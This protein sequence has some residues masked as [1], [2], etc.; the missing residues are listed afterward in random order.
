M[1]PSKKLIELAKQAQLL[2][3]MEK[4]LIYE[5]EHEQREFFDNLRHEMEPNEEDLRKFNEIRRINAQ[6]LTLLT[7][8]EGDI[9][10]NIDKSLEKN[11]DNYISDYEERTTEQWLY[12]VGFRSFK[13]TSN[14]DLGKI[15]NDSN[16]IYDR[17]NFK[18]EQEYIEH[19]A[20]KEE[21]KAGELEYE[22]KFIDTG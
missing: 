13:Q 15:F 21:Q 9:C 8:L 14:D 2:E 3:K 11:S 1:K 18:S 22:I 17:S 12:L 4:N 6:N 5:I 19:L 16:L 10:R 20:W 7:T